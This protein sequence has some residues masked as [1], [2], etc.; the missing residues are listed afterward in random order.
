MSPSEKKSPFELFKDLAHEA[1]KSLPLKATPIEKPPVL[2]PK[3]APV[4][5]RYVS[6]QKEYQ[7]A[8]QDP[9]LVEA[10]LRLKLSRSKKR[11]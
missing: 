5:K 7:P 2:E 6:Y 11:L 10:L 1:H 4:A 3:T 8:L 9:E